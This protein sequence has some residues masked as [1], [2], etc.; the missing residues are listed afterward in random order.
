M[1]IFVIH[2]NQNASGSLVVQ[3]LSHYFVCLVQ[4]LAMQV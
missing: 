1:P 3:K 4:Y 2:L